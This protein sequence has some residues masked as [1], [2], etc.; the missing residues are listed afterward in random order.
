MTT[1]SFGRVGFFFRFALAACAVSAAGHNSRAADAENTGPASAAAGARRVTL[2]RTVEPS[3]HIEP[4]VHRFEARR[5]AVIPFQFLIK[6][7]GKSMQVS[8]AAVS[9]RQEE[10]GIIMHNTDGS[11]PDAVRFTSPIE[12]DLSPG[13]SQLIEGTVT[14]PLAKSNFLSYGVL[15]RDNG[16][17][18][19]G[20]QVASE[21]GKTSAAVRFVTQYVLRVDIETGVKDQSQLDHIVFEDGGIRSEKGMPIARTFLVN[22]TDFAFEFGVRGEIES[23]ARSRSTPFRFSMPSRATLKTDEKY[24]VR[25]MPQSR[26]RLDAPVEQLLF[27]GEQDFKVAVTNGRR[28]VVE[29]SFPINVAA[30]DFPAL[31]TQLAFLGGQLTVEPAQIEVGRTSGAKRTCNLKFVNSSDE[32]RMVSI[33]LKNLVGGP[34]EGVR[35]SDESFEI[36]PRRSKTIRASVQTERDDKSVRF[37]ELHLQVE[38]SGSAAQSLPLALVN[39]AKPTP[40][41]EIGE[42]QSFEQNGV[43]SFRLTATNN[44][45][46][47][48]PIHADLQVADTK[49]RAYELADGYG[50]WLKP[51]ETRELAF[52]PETVLEAGDYQLSL[53]FKT[54]ESQPPVERTLIIKLDPG[55]D[56][57]LQVSEFRVKAK[58]TSVAGPAR[59]QGGSKDGGLRYDR[60]LE[61]KTFQDASVCARLPQTRQNW[62]FHIWADLQRLAR[63]GRLVNSGKEWQTPP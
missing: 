29:K 40:N 33:N 51:G 8:V 49:G 59:V 18:S 20:E 52:I 4:I 41:V 37:G 3:F 21:Q 25:L 35:L 9:L 23:P 12:F 45:E 15:V 63:L 13:E 38:G 32:T 6:S 61:S 44:G 30:G 43:T 60:R 46:G 57:S 62:H 10:S 36:K 26:I 55:A 16:M 42:L 54:T 58:P 28:A 5:G 17:V 2:T 1:R 39:G 34:L 7:T 50:R 19:G 24:L 22:P 53:S 27:P 48:V 11:P 14:V 47:F 31:Q 56:P